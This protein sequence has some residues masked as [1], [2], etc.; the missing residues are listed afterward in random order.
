MFEMRDMDGNLIPV[1]E[2][3]SPVKRDLNRQLDEIRQE[4]K[5]NRW[6]QVFGGQYIGY[7]DNPKRGAPSPDQRK[8]PSAPAWDRGLCNGGEH[9]R[10]AD[11]V[12]CNQCY[13]DNL[14]TIARPLPNGYYLK[15]KPMDAD[16][17]AIEQ[18]KVAT[19]RTAADQLDEFFLTGGR[20]DE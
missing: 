2:D 13:A 9:P 10:F 19:K 12:H 4:A 16:W 1:I 6:Y 14:A 15:P 7:G 3:R 8:E 17:Q 11:P 20:V 5:T 18:W